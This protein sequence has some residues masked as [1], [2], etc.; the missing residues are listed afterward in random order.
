M[1]NHI[2]IGGA[3]FR[4]ACAGLPCGSF[5]I[6]EMI[7][8]RLAP[9]EQRRCSSRPSSPTT[10]VA[11]KD[12]ARA[13]RAIN[14]FNVPIFRRSRSLGAED[15]RQ[16]R[17]TSDANCSSND[18]AIRPR[19]SC[20]GIRELLDNK[21]I[22]SSPRRSFFDN[23]STASLEFSRSFSGSDT[24]SVNTEV[25]AVHLDKINIAPGRG[26]VSSTE[27]INIRACSPYS[28]IEL[29]SVMSS[30]PSLSSGESNFRRRIK[31]AVED[32]F[33]KKYLADPVRL[34]ASRIAVPRQKVNRTRVIPDD[35]LG[36]I[37]CF[38]DVVSFCQVLS[39]IRML[40]F[41]NS[42]ITRKSLF[43]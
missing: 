10:P 4:G 40:S 20:D 26:S 41:Q 5:S 11:T 16:Q 28:R 6:R 2:T 9:P 27:G 3:E 43:I 8:N 7:D 34:S 42:S 24:S 30:P 25:A 13:E 38:L 33:G 29:E 17:Q 19:G 37:L 12:S 22:T 1:K 14:R 15:T 21:V 39:P 18:Y 35:V 32:M 23:C 36:D 31:G